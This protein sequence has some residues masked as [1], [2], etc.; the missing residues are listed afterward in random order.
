MPATFGFHYANLWW[1]LPEKGAYMARGH[2]SQLILVI[3]K[4][5]VVAVMTGVLR[6]NE[7][8]TVS[9]LIDDISRAVKSD[10]AL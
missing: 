3:S 8:Y 4:L 1:S 10:K 9:G 7:F 2:H 5:D 6:D